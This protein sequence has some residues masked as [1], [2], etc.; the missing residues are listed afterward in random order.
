MKEK[1]VFS[2]V[3]HSLIISLIANSF[4]LIQQQPQILWGIIPVFLFVGIF[5]G[6]FIAKGKR[7]K[8]CLHGT[9][10]LYAFYFSLIVS[11]PYQISLA[12]QSIPGDYMTWIWSLVLCAGVLFIVFWIGILCVYLTSA[13]LGFRL[14]LLGL[15]CGLIPIAN[16]VVLF[17]IIKTTTA[18]CLFEMSKDQLNKQRKSQQVCATKYP[19]LMVHGV[20]FRDTKFFN[21]WGRIP[22]EL[23]TNGAKIFYGNH[24]SADSVADCAAVLKA[25][26]LQI[27]AETGAEKVNIIAHSKGGLDCRYAIAHLGIADRVA[28]LTTINTPHRGCQFADYLLT[29][30]PAD[31]QNSVANT[32]NS[33][34]RKLGEQDADFLAAVNDLTASRCQQLDSEMPVP[35]GI[36]C[37]SVGSVL[38]KASGG[39]FPLNFTYHLANHFSG[40]NDGLVSEDSFAW[41]EHYTLLRSP[42]KRGISHGDMI[43]LN[44]ENIPGFDVR[45]FYVDL[46]NDLKNK[47][48]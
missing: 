9:I 2:A 26:I 14:R 29:N 4:V 15:V 12:V 38:T 44:R 21:Y 8:I 43:D 5:A 37:H 18:E 48:L 30:I 47:G 35:D 13:Q 40:E 27:L 31:T 1:F 46:V 25:R 39:T 19:I 17:L 3:I 11:I 10:L 23:E 20:F 32:Y 36:F 6:T 16:L 41:G 7:S 24:P 42:G 34:L 33:A 28:S 22:E 45:E